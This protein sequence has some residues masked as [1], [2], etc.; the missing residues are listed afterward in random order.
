MRFFSYVIFLYIIYIKRKQIKAI[1]DYLKSK[2][3]W[4]IKVFFWFA[5]I[6]FLF[7]QLTNFFSHFYIKIILKIFVH[8]NI[9]KHIK[10]I[11]IRSEMIIKLIMYKKMFKQIKKKLIRQFFF[12]FSDNKLSFIKQKNIFSNNKILICSTLI[13]L[14]I[15]QFSNFS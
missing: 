7:K 4:D 9:S 11:S 14:Q 8:S 2:W 13:T 1:Y 15:R 6:K 10:R 12:L 3:I 5:N